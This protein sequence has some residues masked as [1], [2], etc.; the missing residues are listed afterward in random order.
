M[1][2]GYVKCMKCQRG[3]FSLKHVV[4][5][6]EWGPL[7]DANIGNTW[8]RDDLLQM[9]NVYDLEP[10]DVTDEYARK[11]KEMLPSMPIDTDAAATQTETTKLPQMNTPQMPPPW[12]Q[13]L[14]VEIKKRYEHKRMIAE[15]RKPNATPDKFMKATSN[16]P[17][18]RTA[19][20]A[21]M[22]TNSSNCT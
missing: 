2:K 20:M 4:K 11:D 1:G 9:Y 22:A 5:G 18:P 21:S 12:A 19:S 15:D 6:P 14:V 10:P 16:Y 3:W 17:S 13:S 7:R 8:E